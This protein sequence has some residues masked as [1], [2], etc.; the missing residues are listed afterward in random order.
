MKLSLFSIGLTLALSCFALIGFGQSSILFGLQK[1]NTTNPQT[2]T[3]QGNPIVIN[4]GNTLVSWNP[5]LNANIYNMVRLN[6]ATG[7]LTAQMG[8]DSII[9]V[10][11]NCATYDPWTKDYVVL[12]NN[13]PTI[14]NAFLHKTNIITGNTSK[15]PYPDQDYYTIEL[16]YD[17][18]RQKIFCIRLNPGTSSSQGY[19]EIGAFDAGTRVYT[20]EVSFQQMAGP[21]TGSS[22]F[23]ANHGIYYI[24]GSDNASGTSLYAYHVDS[25]T[26]S[27]VPLNGNLLYMDLEYDNNLDR[28]YGII[29]TTTAFNPMEIV[30]FD[31]LT[32]SYTTKASIPPYQQKGT[33]CY[34]YALGNYYFTTGRDAWGF[35]ARILTFNANSETVTSN[36]P[37]QDRVYELKCDNS[38]FVQTKYGA[39]TALDESLQDLKLR[40]YPIPATDRVVLE[41]SDALVS[42]QAVDFQLIGLDGQVVRAGELHG[43][44][45]EL[46][47]DGFANGVY[48]LRVQSGNRSYSRRVVFQ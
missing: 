11:D 37:L 14:A 38:E 32:G 8:T 36:V 29:G 41:L 27:K 46:S 3:V 28:L 13:E 34:D 44:Q 19:Y 4:G 16:Q 45:Y 43:N 35:P 25:M 2:V 31:P 6:P 22:T 47:R 9:G 10:L 12:S 48:L 7:L 1:I 5:D 33:A 39:V 18:V 21:A 26:V 24:I 30:Q 15:F 42:G 17:P 20:T 23:D 40:V